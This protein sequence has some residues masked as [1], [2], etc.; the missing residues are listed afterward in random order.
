MDASRRDL[1]SESPCLFVQWSFFIL[2]LLLP[3]GPICP[4]LLSPSLFSI[5]FHA[6]SHL[7]SHFPFPLP[8]PLVDYITNSTYNLVYQVNRPVTNLH[9]SERS[10]CTPVGT[11]SRGSPLL[12]TNGNIS[13]SRPH[14][15][16]RHHFIRSLQAGTPSS[17]TTS[18]V[19][20]GTTSYQIRLR[21]CV[22]WKG[23]RHAPM[24]RWQIVERQSG[25]GQLFNISWNGRQAWR[26]RFNISQWKDPRQPGKQWWRQG[27]IGR[28]PGWIS[29]QA[30]WSHET[31]LQHHH[32]RR[33]APTPHQLLR[34]IT[35]NRPQLQPAFYWS[36]SS[37]YSPTKGS[38]PRVNC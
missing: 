10:S 30:R 22:G 7:F 27:W 32:V 36:G 15:G 19:G 9:Q 35:S 29:I 13:R 24:D 1:I 34:P 21:I 33:T 18:P 38:L 31:V 28:W 3:S 17:R 23:S 6:S 20:K 14:S 4:Y 8:L 12:T 16:G 37:K 2:L 11:G 25:F 5:F 26:R